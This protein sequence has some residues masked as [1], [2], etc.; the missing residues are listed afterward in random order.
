MHH[1]YNII[2]KGLDII[3]HGCR[4]GT[5]IDLTITSITDFHVMK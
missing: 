4:S 2:L 5:L 3:L 1:Y